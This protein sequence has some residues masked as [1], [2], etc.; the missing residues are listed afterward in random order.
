MSNQVNKVNPRRWDVVQ[1]FFRE[2]GPPAALAA[3]YAGFGYFTATPRPEWPVVTGMFGS[4][5][6]IISW[7]WSQVHRINK[8]LRHD[9]AF[10]EIMGGLAGL[11]DKLAAIEKASETVAS[12]QAPTSGPTNTHTLVTTLPNSVVVEA[13]ASPPPQALDAASPV[14]ATEIYERTL[15]SEA[16]A[17][18]GAGN[19]RAGM[20]IA[21]S[22]MEQALRNFAEAHGVVVGRTEGFQRV[23]QKAR[24]YLPPGLA[25]DLERIWDMRN[26]T[27]HGH[28]TSAVAST[29]TS[30][31]LPVIR[32]VVS[33]LMTATIN[34]QDRFTGIPC[35]RC[36]RPTMGSGGAENV[37]GTCGAVSDGD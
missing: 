10:D 37:C 13:P 1:R 16:E 7:L 35:F 18:I 4:A 26:T 28:L 5:W 34:R 23:L 17:A 11:Y 8:Q 30:Q 21:G 6:F 2:L 25:E 14:T 29:S 24:D 36:A 3:A 32:K 20:V 15:L 22:A 33:S 19:L 31:I 12:K 27:A 9:N